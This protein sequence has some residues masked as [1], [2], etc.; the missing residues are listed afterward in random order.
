MSGLGHFLLAHAQRELLSWQ[1]QLEAAS[2]FGLTLHEV[3]HA[4]FAAGLLPA[5]Y[6]RNQKT[7]SVEQ[8]AVLF[9]SKVA[10]I[11]CGGLGGYVLEELARL[12]VGHIVPVDFDVF[13]EHNLNRQI[14]SSPANLNT[15]KV[16]AAAERIEHINPAVQ[17]LPCNAP[18]GEDSAAV[19][20]NGCH[21]CVDAL[22]S[23]PVR[24]LLSR[25]CTEQGIPLIHGAICGWYG[26][27]ATQF[28]GEDTLET[29]YRSCTLEKGMEKDYGNPS[30]TPAVTAS[31]QVAE[32][33]KVLLGLGSV[34]RRR[35]LYINLLD[36][37]LEEWQQ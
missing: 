25:F 34:L 18:F 14:L 36:M 27:V 16:T 33:C 23:I 9:N 30:F 4:V 28:P 11:G 24:L 37:E 5:R 1:A 12:G 22:D 20:L 31:L 32:V 21:A 2:R 13:E 7:L 29:L 19:I 15:P 26:Q 10:V 17:V 35:V 6:Q 3:E 8:Q